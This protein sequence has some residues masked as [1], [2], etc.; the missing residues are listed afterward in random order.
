MLS[1]MLGRDPVVSKPML[2]SHGLD[3]GGV[4]AQGGVSAQAVVPAGFTD[5][6]TLTGLTAPTVVQFAPDGRVFV[7]EKRGI[8]KV[9]D[10]L[11]DTTP[12]TFADLRPQVDD[13]W[14]RGLLGMALP[15]N[16]PTNPYVYVLYT[17]DAPIGGTAPVW[18]DACP[19]PPGPTTDGCVVSGR[20]SRFQAAGDVA[21]GPEQV[22]I[23]DW[24]QQHPSHSIGTVAFGPD[25]ALYVSGGD[26]ASF[27]VADY[28]QTGGS[29]PNTPTPVNPCA[30]PVG[31]GGALRSQDLRTVPT[32]GGGGGG[33]PTYSATVLADAPVAY[34]RLG[35][36]SGT[37]AVDQKATSPGTYTGSYALGQA[38]ALSADT[39]TSI[40][41]GPSAGYVSVPDDPR[42]D[43]GDGPFSIEFWAKRSGTGSGYLLNKGN[44]GYGVFF[45]GSD[46]KLHFEKVNTQATAQESGTTDQAWHHWAI[47][48]GAGTANAIIYKDGVNSTTPNNQSTFVDT[49]SPL[50]IGRQV[51]STPFFGGLDEVA[52]YNK[53][54]TGAQ[55]AAHY[56]ART[57]GGGTPPP[58]DPTTLDGGI[59]RLDPNTGAALPDNPNAAGTDENARRIVAYGHR[60]PFRFT[61]RPG[62]SEMW[63]GDV[64]WD[65]W[66][67]ID[68]IANPAAG[69]VNDGWPCYEGVGTQ[70][71]YDSRNLGICENL[72]AAGAGAVGAPYY[73]YNHTAAVVAGDTCPTAN[74]SSI[75]GL[76]F[77]NGGTYPASYNGGLFFSDY[78]RR[79]IWFMPK[80]ANGRPNTAAIAAAVTPAVNPVYLTIGPGGDLV[81]VDYDGG[82]I[83]RLTYSGGGGNQAPTAAPSATPTSGAAPLAV[84]F[85]GTASSDPEGGALTYAWDFDGNGTD[86]ATTATANF[87]YTTVGTYAARLRVTDHAGPRTARRSRSTSATRRRCRRS[88]VRL[89]A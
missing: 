17:Y 48:Q 62:T 7:A 65:A 4:T 56:A 24:C 3:A 9:F 70:P 41:V 52:I 50:E 45:A 14:D 77:Y 34:W 20:L 29:L 53:T 86:D 67:E 5:Q 73:A 16:F 82:T 51:S 38:G 35:E 66:E 71:T 76:A 25:G 44:G 36:T 6:Q 61:F 79:C 46:N 74:G 58:S 87:T 31:E 83:H 23:N 42:F 85:S 49:A 72:Y 18:N 2:G 8:I 78:T 19:T 84:A 60:N 88:R 27:D 68:L 30:D 55:V 75:S 33:G 10:S 21:T 12:T 15:P 69:M 1:P 89:R 59:L 81:Y 28:G 22:L 32:G 37:T 26:G 11:S 63:I 40:S 57:A 80:L 47:V 43:L 13:Y 39:D 54:L 64:G